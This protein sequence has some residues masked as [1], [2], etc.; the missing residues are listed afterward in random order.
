MFQT[1]WLRLGNPQSISVLRLPNDILTV[2]QEKSCILILRQRG[3][4]LLCCLLLHAG[5]LVKVIEKV[6][7]G[8][9][10]SKA[11]FISLFHSTGR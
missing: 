8:Q 5:N 1:P 11:I 4:G 2:F 9:L 7:H 10:T 3:K 6:T